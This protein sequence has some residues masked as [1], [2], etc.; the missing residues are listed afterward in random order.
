MSGG[1]IT[2]RIDEPSY[3]RVVKTAIEIIPSGFGIVVISAIPEGVGSTQGGSHGTGGGLDIALGVVV[4]SGNGCSVGIVNANNVALCVLSKEILRRRT[5]I[6]IV[7]KTD[8]LAGGIVLIYE[9]ALRLKCGCGTF[10]E[11]VYY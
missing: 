1:N 9:I 6:G 10:L 5:G 7:G 2:V 3:L 4:V 11:T 8:D